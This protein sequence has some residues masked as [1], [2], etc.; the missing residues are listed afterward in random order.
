MTSEKLTT[1][2][3]EGDEGMQGRIFVDIFHR[4][5]PDGVEVKEPALDAKLMA[6]AIAEQLKKRSSYRRATTS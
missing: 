5:F 2:I 4:D 3:C 1:L 6:E